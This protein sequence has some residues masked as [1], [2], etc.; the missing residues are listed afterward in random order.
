MGMERFIDGTA[1]SFEL[2]CSPFQ[3]HGSLAQK[4]NT[5]VQAKHTRGKLRLFVAL[6]IQVFFSRLTLVLRLED[7]SAIK[8]GLD[9]RFH[10]FTRHQ[11]FT[12]CRL[13]CCCDLPCFFILVWFAKFYSETRFVRVLFVEPGVNLNAK[14]KENV[15]VSWHARKFR[16]DLLHGIWEK[17]KGYT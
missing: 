12:A 8:Q 17:E 7:R 3:L 14:Q 9:R 6:L 1:L 5:R 2:C 15:E 13:H 4:K 16:L 10:H 11:R